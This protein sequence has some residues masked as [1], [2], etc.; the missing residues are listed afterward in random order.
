MY[1]YGR[2]PSSQRDIRA[3]LKPSDELRVAITFHAPDGGPGLTKFDAPLSPNSVQH[4]VPNA[5]DMDRA[6]FGLTKMGFVLSRRGRMTA[7]MRTS[8]AE[9]EKVCG[10]QL[11]VQQVDPKRGYAYGSFYFPAQGSPWKPDPAFSALIDDAYIQW[12]HIYMTPKK[13]PKKPT[14]AA[15]AVGA[16]GPAVNPPKVN[17]FHLEMPNDVPQLLNV[18]DVHKAGVT[19]KGVRVVMVDTGFAH[20]SH[21]FFAANGFTSTVDLAPHAI[22]DATDPNGHGTGESTNIFSVAPN[23]TFIGVKVENDNDP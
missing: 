4:F 14:K 13:R 17:Y 22:S 8:R 16:G 10:T 2:G 11:G 3:T 20:T 23:A 5:V 21:P 9:Y 7:S 15:G 12:P 18:K 1:A 19:G 6:I